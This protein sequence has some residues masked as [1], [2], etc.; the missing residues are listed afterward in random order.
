M[1]S[2]ALLAF[3]RNRAL[4]MAVARFSSPAR[5]LLYESMR[6]LPL[7]PQPKGP[8]TLPVPDPRPRQRLI[9]VV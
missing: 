9:R 8:E 6:V 2:L 5:L 4:L 1:L 3:L 7:L